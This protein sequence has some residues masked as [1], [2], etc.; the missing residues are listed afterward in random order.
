MRNGPTGTLFNKAQSLFG[1]SVLEFVLGRCWG[2][3]EKVREKLTFVKTP[4]GPKAPDQVSKIISYSQM[5]SGHYS[6]YAWIPHG[7]TNTQLGK[8]FW[9]QNFQPQ[10]EGI[11]Y[12]GFSTACQMCASETK[13][14]GNWENTRRGLWFV[15]VWECMSCSMKPCT[16]TFIPANVNQPLSFC[17]L[18]HESF[19]KTHRKHVKRKEKSTNF[20]VGVAQFKKHNLK[21]TKQ[22]D[23]AI[24]CKL[25]TFVAKLGS[26]NNF[27]FP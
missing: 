17:P 26:R 14:V 2:G 21:G 8:T 10:P 15:G 1:F 16:C 18:I 19:G 23:I 27:G 9:T 4:V 22:I 3:V 24:Y 6:S 20:I 5:L 11:G 25:Q 12:G 13:R 7:Q